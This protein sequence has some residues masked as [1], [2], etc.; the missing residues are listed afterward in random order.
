M[1]DEQGNPATAGYMIEVFTGL[2]PIPVDLSKVT[3]SPSDAEGISSKAARLIR[4]LMVVADLDPIEDADEVG[5][6]FPGNPQQKQT[7]IELI[8]GNA[9][10]NHEELEEQIGKLSKFC[11]LQFDYGRTPQELMEELKK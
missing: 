10:W 1:R 9:T 4:K 6:K 3:I 7:A 11:K 2:R 5:G 8:K